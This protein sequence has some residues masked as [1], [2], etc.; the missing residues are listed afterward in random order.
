MPLPLCIMSLGLSQHKV[1]VHPYDPE[2]PV[3]YEQEANRLRTALD[4]WILSIEH[5]GSTAVP[6]MPAKPIVDIAIGIRN[7]EEGFEMVPLMTELGY[8][9]RGEV[10][11]PR[12][13]FYMLGKPRTHHV[14]VYEITS[15]DWQQRITFRDVLRSDP[16]KAREYAELKQKLAEQFPRDISSYLNGKKDFIERIAKIAT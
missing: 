8:H 9:F 1:E 4:D 10:G 3:L 6:G 11:V 7:F 12:R 13:H 16:T 2:W 5:I 14:H 15:Q